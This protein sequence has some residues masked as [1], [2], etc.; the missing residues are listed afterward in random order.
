[1]A[2]SKD[3]LRE[4][5]TQEFD[6]FGVIKSET[7]LTYM[8]SIGLSYDEADLSFETLVVVGL[9]YPH[10]RDLTV[11]THSH[12]VSRYAFGND[13]HRV[14]RDRLARIASHFED[15]GIQT[16]YNVDV[17]PLNERVTG[18]LAGLGYIGKSQF[19][20]NKTY[21][22]YFFIGTMLIDQPLLE[23]STLNLDSC[24]A[25]RRCI[26]ACP[27]HALDDGYDKKKC[28]SYFSQIKEPLSD[29]EIGKI[30]S[31]MGCDVCQTVCPKNFKISI[32]RHEEFMPLGNEKIHFESL[33]YMTNKEF[34]A[35]Y[36]ASAFAWRG[37]LLLLRNALCI[38]SQRNLAY[39]IPLIKESIE[40][41]QDIAW[42][43]AT[44]EKVLAHLE[45]L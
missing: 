40:K 25:C 24:H 36:Q 30:D 31:L 22:T 11:D 18:Y 12:T 10:D 29:Y 43:K 45:A 3:Q 4:L 17:N 8:Q 9:N 7:Y 35:L 44:A 37:K 16:R 41:N 27:T 21:G 38:I 6:L 32:K 20:I 26:D 2:L 13:Y 33:F 15:Q 28:I 14:L 5:F 23:E 19:L 1:M 34:K 42:Y 39:Y